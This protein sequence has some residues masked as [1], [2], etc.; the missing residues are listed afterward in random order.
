MQAIKV[1]ELAGREF[2]SP[3]LFIPKEAPLPIPRW[4]PSSKLPSLFLIHSVLPGTNIAPSKTIIGSDETGRE[5]NWLVS[6]DTLL[7]EVKEQTEKQV[8]LLN[9]ANLV[10]AAANLRSKRYHETI[11][12]DPEIFLVD[13]KGELIPAFELFD[14]KSKTAIGSPY[15]DGY[16][17][18]FNVSPDTCMDSLCYRIQ[19]AL[20]RTQSAARKKNKAADLTMQNV[21]DVSEERRNTDDKKYVTFGCTP[22]LNVY[23][24]TFP[25]VDAKLVP[26]RSAGGHLHLALPHGNKNPHVVDIVKELDRILG[27]I[28]VCMFQ[29]YDSP[30]RRALYGKA[31]EYRLPKHGMEYRV[32]SNAWLV[33]PVALHTVYEIA[34]LCMGMYVMGAKPGPW[35]EWDV[36]EDEARQCINTCDVDMAKSLIKRNETAFSLLLR[37]LPTGGGYDK[38]A[39]DFVIAWWKGM[40]LDG[41]HTVMN[42]PEY[43][44][45]DWLLETDGEHYNR[46]MATVSHNLAFLFSKGYKGSITLE[47]LAAKLNSGNYF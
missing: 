40:L 21:F 12:A 44:S 11:G 2:T 6:D 22:S 43:P 33:H 38:E 46:N 8:A 15:W 28:S 29:F 3:V 39:Q 34:R 13:G 4:G 37:A 47:T 19:R 32:L 30:R 42:A 14:E 24:E 18:E 27:V 5:W 16:Q 41:V 36:T 10:H 25:E 7:E 35:A 9:A 23:G 20:S 31:G 1:S 45:S 26:F 17:A